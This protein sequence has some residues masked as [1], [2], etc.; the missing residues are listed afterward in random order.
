MKLHFEFFENVNILQINNAFIDFKTAKPLGLVE[1]SI[2]IASSN[3]KLTENKVTSFN[4]FQDVKA[5]RENETLKKIEWAFDHGL[6]TRFKNIQI[7]ESIHFDA[8]IDYLG[9]GKL[10]ESTFTPN[11]VKLKLMS[12]QGMELRLNEGLFSFVKKAVKKVG[13]VVSSGVKAVAKGAVAVGKGYVTAAKAVGGAIVKGAKAVGKVVG[14][15]LGAAF[16]FAKKMLGKLAELAMSVIKGLASFIGKNIVK[17]IDMIPSIMSKL[18]AVITKMPV[19]GKILTAL[20]GVGCI[21]KAFMANGTN[22]SYNPRESFDVVNENFFSKLSVKAAPAAPAAPAATEAEA[23]VPAAPAT[24]TAPAEVAAPEAGVASTSVK[25]KRQKTGFI[26]QGMTMFG[27]A[28]LGKTID[29]D[30]LTALNTGVGAALSAGNGKISSILP[31]IVKNL[32]TKAG[33]IGEKIKETFLNPAKIVAGLFST[34]LQGAN[35]IIAFL[36]KTIGGENL[37][38]TLLKKAFSGLIN[39]FQEILMPS[40]KEVAAPVAAPAEDAAAAAAA[41]GEAE[42]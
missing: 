19:I 10:K 18:K 34:L 2:R 9:Y 41:D 32:A 33:G 38:G 3:G 37:I 12:L 8:L 6:T 13:S 23:A 15:A 31:Y 24:P 40:K 27:L 1:A 30:T 16:D 11:Y 14:N 5:L 22:E 42:N 25:A 26:F 7:D 4:D 35:P 21:I 28:A 39:K 36:W 20:V 29:K 17:L